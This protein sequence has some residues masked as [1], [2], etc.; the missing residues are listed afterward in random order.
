M[1]RM[2]LYLPRTS[3]EQERRLSL[4]LLRPTPEMRSLNV[5]SGTRIGL[6][7]PLDPSRRSDIVLL[8]FLT[9]AAA[10]LRLLYLSARSLTLDEGY[11]IFL[12]WT[13]PVDFK[14]YVWRSELNMVLYYSLLRLWIRLGSSEFV[15]RSLSVLFAAATL[16]VIYF[17]GR[18]LFGRST[19]LIASLLLAIHPFHLILA[20][21]A[22]S[23]SLLIFLVSTSSLFFLRLVEDPSGIN[24]SA[25][26]VLSAAAVYSHF[27]AALII[28]AQWLSL[29]FLTGRRLPWR[30]L[31]MS[32]VLLIALLVP[33]AM[34]LLHS[35]ARNVGW[36]DRLSW[37]QML[38]VLY[39]LTLSKARCLTYLALW[40]AGLW[41]VFRPVRDGEA[42]PYR[43]TVMWLLVPPAITLVA[44]F[45]RPVLV[46]RYLAVCLP[47]AVLFAASGLS[48][49]ARWSRPAAGVVLLLILFY[50]LS[51][52]RFYDRHPEFEQDW[53]GASD[54]VLS[55][56]QAGDEVLVDGYTRFVVDYYFAR[57]RVKVPLQAIAESASPPLAKPAPA[58]VWFI[59]AVEPASGFSD[60]AASS[61]E[62]Q[63][64]QE[65]YGESYCALP[66]YPKSGIVRVWQF[67]RCGNY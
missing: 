55:R 24:C 39:S 48:R 37:Q 15:V 45:A 16:P 33:V 67:Q 26:A 35:G 60:P 9:V 12:A 14:T 5:E 59:G 53:R 2:L 34:F 8:L 65:L 56:M 38:D 64:F 46:P 13:G 32:I 22:R 57:S 44:S 27:F 54:Y 31:L 4:R 28:L 62:V 20:Q 21:Q 18:R 51:A 42:W 47:A 61:T 43:F 30:G 58:D 1:N 17:L 6:R 49:L 25:Y 63:T 23:Y 10:A 40:T 11:S 3:R 7:E 19:A 36:V 29:L 66:A 50:S 52:I 41:R